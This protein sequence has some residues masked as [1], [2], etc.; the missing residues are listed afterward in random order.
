K[1]EL[2]KEPVEFAA[3]VRNAVEASKPL[4]E[5]AEH[6]LAIT[7]PAEPLTLN[8]DPMR[9]AQVL[10]NLLNNA[11]KYTERGG[12]I[13]LTARRDGSQLVVSVRDNGIGIPAAM[14]PKV[15]D[16]FTQIDRTPGRAQSG[17]GIGLTLAR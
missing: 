6:Q 8:A 3:I 11:A 10:T 12:Q 5:A 16:L 15:F 13:W 1:I 17:L 4:I 14:L 2:R 9:L 7:L